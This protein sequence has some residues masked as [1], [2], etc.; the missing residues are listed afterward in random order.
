M[1]LSQTKI[2]N[3]FL[4]SVEQ[5]SALKIFSADCSRQTVAYIPNKE[6]WLSRFFLNRSCK[7]KKLLSKFFERLRKI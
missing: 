2:F 1:I 5:S 7:K 6:L 3:V 4:G